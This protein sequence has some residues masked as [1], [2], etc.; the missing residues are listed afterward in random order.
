MTYDSMAIVECC[1]CVCTWLSALLSN[2]KMQSIL[3]L[4]PILSSHF[5]LFRISFLFFVALEL[6]WR[7][8]AWHVA[9]I[10]CVSS[11]LLCCLSHRLFSGP[12]LPLTY[13]THFSLHF[14]VVAFPIALI[15]SI[16]DWQICHYIHSLAVAVMERGNVRNR[17]VEEWRINAKRIQLQLHIL[18]SWKCIFVSFLL[19]IFYKFN[20]SKRNLDLRK[21]QLHSADCRRITHTHT[22]TPKPWVQCCCAISCKASH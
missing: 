4:L 17:I 1:S 8:L 11:S 7:G 12:T 22:R 16:G 15:Q 3:L 19:K 18:M 2:A 20:R 13:H 9:C 10:L 6:V 21:S 5:R 14:V